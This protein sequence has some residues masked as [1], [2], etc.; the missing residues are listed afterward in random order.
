MSSQ[1]SHLIYLITAQFEVWAN[2]ILSTMQGSIL[3]LYILLALVQLIFYIHTQMAHEGLV[4]LAS[5]YFL[6]TEEFQVGRLSCSLD[7]VISL[8]GYDG[9]KITMHGIMVEARR[10]GDCLL[11]LRNF[12]RIPLDSDQCLCAPNFDLLLMLIGTCLSR[13]KPFHVD[14]RLAIPC[15]NSWSL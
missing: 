7:S 12:T 2:F 14:G 13:Y 8:S 3:E 10:S 4:W 11:K 5:R 1:I 9:Q 15:Q 6:L